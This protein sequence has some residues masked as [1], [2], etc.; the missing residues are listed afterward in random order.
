M[1]SQSRAIV[2]FRSTCRLL[3]ALAVAGLAVAGV[4]SAAGIY[5]IVPLPL[6][7]GAVTYPTVAGINNADDA[8]GSLTL[9]HASRAVAWTAASGYAPRLLPMGNAT[10]ATAAAINDAGDIVGQFLNNPRAVLWRGEDAILLATPASS[11]S[12]ARHIDAHGVVYGNTAHPFAGTWDTIWSTPSTPRELRYDYLRGPFDQMGVRGINDAGVIVGFA[13]AYA[14]GNVHAFRRSQ[15]R[16]VQL[17]EELPDQGSVFL[18][19]ALDVNNAGQVVG[20]ALSSSTWRALLWNRN[21]SVRDL[22]GIPAYEN[23]SYHAQYINDLGVVT[24][25]YSWAADGYQG[26]VWTAATGMR[27]IVDLID[28]QDPLYPLVAAGTPLLIQGINNKGTMIAMLGFNADPAA[29]IPVVLV[30]Q[31]PL[32]PR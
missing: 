28:P 30:P 10:G 9:D 23:A 20:E 1:N 14:D 16:R 3:A 26:F 24:G 15:G 13:S 4:A 31:L 32:H 19:D 17:L 8:V 18:Y 27:S 21:G 5:R 12:D 29:R 11:D 6:P 7:P 22:G 2:F 25:S